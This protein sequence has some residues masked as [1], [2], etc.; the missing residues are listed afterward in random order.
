MGVYIPKMQVPET[1]G[2]CL[3]VGWHYVFDCHIDECDTRMQSC[4]LVE[5]K[6]HGRLIEANALMGKA[7][8]YEIHGKPTLKVVL[9]SALRDAPTIIE[10][11]VQDE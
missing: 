2:K 3:D 6:P 4:P 5:V 8:R 9:A 7:F 1:C 10:A 11:E